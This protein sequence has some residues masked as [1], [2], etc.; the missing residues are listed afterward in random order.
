MSGLLDMSIDELSATWMEAKEAERLAVERRRAV[1][2][3][4][5]LIMEL[6]PDLDGT[7]TKKDLSSLGSFMFMGLIGII[8]ASVVNL[9]LGSAMISWVVSAIGVI[10]FTGL[11][12]YD[13][14]KISMYGATG[15][16]AGGEDVIRKGA[17]LGALTLYLDF[18]NLFLSLLRLMGDRR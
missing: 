11:T 9:F 4:L 5:V 12:A 18:I 7:V 2:D 13:V 14:Q 6:S 16:M 10:V 8:I 3:H 15:V 1:E 17:I